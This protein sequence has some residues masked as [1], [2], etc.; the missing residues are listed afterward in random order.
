MLSTFF[1]SENCADRCR[2]VTE[3]DEDFGGVDAIADLLFL[4][5][6]FIQARKNIAFG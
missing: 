5:P 6:L 2:H 1:P 4:V 3:E